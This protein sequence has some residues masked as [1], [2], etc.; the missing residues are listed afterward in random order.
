MPWYVWL[1][2]GLVSGF[3]IAGLC[4]SYCLKKAFEDWIPPWWR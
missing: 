3:V 2:I 1:T 4:V